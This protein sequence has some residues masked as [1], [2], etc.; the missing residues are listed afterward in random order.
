LFDTYSFL[1]TSLFGLDCASAVLCSYTTVLL[2]VFL[3]L[4]FLLLALNWLLGAVGQVG[5][6]FRLC[7]ISRDLFCLCFFAFH[8]V[9]GRRPL[10]RL[11]PASTFLTGLVSEKKSPAMHI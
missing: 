1:L 11:L 9:W 8:T 2:C 5:F 10:E 3:F 7:F 4:F 6:L